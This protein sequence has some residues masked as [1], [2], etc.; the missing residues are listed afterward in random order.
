MKKY[1]D[2]ESVAIARACMQG[3]FKAALSIL[4]S[5]GYKTITTDPCISKGNEK[6]GNTLNFSL[7]AVYGCTTE[8]FKT[9]ARAFLTGEKTLSCYAVKDYRNKSVVYARFCNLYYAK[10][11]KY[12]LMG[13]IIRTIR[14]ELKKRENPRCKCYRK[15]LYFRLHESGDF[16]SVEYLGIWIDIARM[17]PQVTFYTYSKAFSVLIQKKDNIPAN[18][19]ILLSAWNGL[20]IPE[21]L[22][23][24]FPVAY[25]SENTIPNSVSCPAT[26][27]KKDTMNCERCGYLCAKNYNVRFNPH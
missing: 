18:L 14:E 11:R 22:R 20:E 2:N 5:R 6:I 24:R 21:E 1:F 4:H 27:S 23:E 8:C 9:C 25:V 12:E 13:F 16:F 26:G 7:P 15:P 10:K 19:R 17:F 3:N